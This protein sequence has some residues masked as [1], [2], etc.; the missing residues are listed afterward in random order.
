[1]KVICARCGKLLGYK[2][3]FCG[4]YVQWKD[5]NCPHCGNDMKYKHRAGPEALPRAAAELRRKR[6]PRG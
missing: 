5:I 4:A 3:P 1:M 6:T 2:C